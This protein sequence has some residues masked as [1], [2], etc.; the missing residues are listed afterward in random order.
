MNSADAR[1]SNLRGAFALSPAQALKGISHIALIDDVVTTM[2]TS[3]VISKLI[4]AQL[5]CQIDV[6]CLARAS[7]QN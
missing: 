7:R 2:A 5:D 3:E 6:W 4:R 1:K